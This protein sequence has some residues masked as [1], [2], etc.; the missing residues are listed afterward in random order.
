MK[1]YS[2]AIF[3][4]SLRDDF[5]KYSDRDLLIVAENHQTLDLLKNKFSGKDWSISYYTYSKL[6]FLSL[7]GSLFLKHLQ[8]ESEIIADKNNKLKNILSNHKLKNNYKNEIK[9]AINYFEIL[10]Y[11]PNTSQGYAWLCDCLYVGLRNYL[12]FKNTENNLYLFSFIQLL[13]NLEN[14]KQITDEE[15]KILREIRVI[16]RNY[17]EANQDFLPSLPFIMKVLKIFNKL[18]LLPSFDIINPIIFRIHIENNILSDNFNSYQ[19]L[20]LLEGYYCSQNINIPEIKKI[21][22]TPQFYAV[23][24]KDKDYVQNLIR[25]IKQH[26]ITH[27]LPKAAITASI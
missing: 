16:K 10:K 13:K 11:I 21:V 4:S 20:R 7:K 14:Q 23:K 17:R 9:E 22:N 27:G 12:I 18:N 5:D 1:D 3:G 24:F 2:I 26:H 6:E 19:K 25:R 15:V 8:I